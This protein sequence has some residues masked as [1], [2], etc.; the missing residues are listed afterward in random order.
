MATTGSILSLIRHSDTV[1]STERK[2][3]HVRSC[4]SITGLPRCLRACSQASILS[5]LE[6]NAE[7]ASG[8]Q[9]VS[10]STW[11]AGGGER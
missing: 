5:S 10:L 1:V 6:A 4:V 2:V 11:E 7:T 8:V 3:L 9:G